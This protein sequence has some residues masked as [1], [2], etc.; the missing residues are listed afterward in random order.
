M[1]RQVNAVLDWFIPEDIPKSEA[2]VAMVRNFVLLH[3][4]GPLM[5]HFVVGFLWVTLAESAWQ[6][7]IIECSVLAFFLVPFMLRWCGDMKIPAMFSVQLLVGLSLFGSFYFG[8]ISSPLL[9]WFLIAMV[10]GFFYLAD[11]TAQVLAGI[12]LQIAVFVG[13]RMWL[14]SFPNLVDISD[15]LVANSLSILAATTYMTLLCLFYENVMRLSRASLRTVFRFMLLNPSVVR[16]PSAS[17][18]MR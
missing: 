9:P 2:D 5:G 17:T 6:L 13:C 12:A 8:G 10:L 14:G 11:S 3:L 7:W 18:V 1:Y 15:L 4:L 16:R